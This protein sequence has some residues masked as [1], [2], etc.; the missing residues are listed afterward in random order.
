MER[1]KLVVKERSETGTRAVRRL[2]R[3]GLIPGVLYGAGKSAAVAV[4][5]HALREAMSTGAG[6]HAV[7]DVVFEGK[8]RAHTAI[9]QDLELDKVKHT[10][11]HIDLHEIH[12]NEP[13]ETKLSVH[14]EGMAKGVKVGGL[15][16]IVTHE[17]TVRGLPVDIPEHLSM[18]I[19][20]IDIGDV[21]RVRDLVVPEGLTVLDD[22]EETVFHIE[23]PRVLEVEE[24]AEEEAVPAAAGEPELVGKAGEELAAE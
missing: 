4:E 24:V 2:R 3:D 5:A 20:D 17:V 15:L 11:V 12:L 19:E 14:L 8:K 18:S 6:R 10:I 9:I 1:V 21:V 7:L 22:P 16:D 13:I 23:P